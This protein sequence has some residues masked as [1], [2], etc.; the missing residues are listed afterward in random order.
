MSKPDS[1][2]WTKK[3]KWLLPSLLVRKW[4]VFF[5]PPFIY[6]FVYLFIY[7]FILQHP[8]RMPEDGWEA[9]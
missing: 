7:L 4:Q 3:S 5:L 9:E 8:L 1:T 2:D 6:L